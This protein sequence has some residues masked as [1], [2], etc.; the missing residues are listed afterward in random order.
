LAKFNLEGNIN[1]EGG[2]RGER[3]G[4]VVVIVVVDL[5]FNPHFVEFSMKLL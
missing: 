5:V 3:G 4:S 2:K 1:K